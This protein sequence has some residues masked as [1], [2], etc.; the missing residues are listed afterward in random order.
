MVTRLHLLDYLGSVCVLVGAIEGGSR[1]G[2]DA[3]LLLLAAVLPVAVA[4]GRAFARGLRAIAMLL[5]ILRW[6]KRLRI[7]VREMPLRLDL[8]CWEVG[9]AAVGLY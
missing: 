7:T 3:M 6:S 8:L 9:R 4:D 1:S 2:G 5:T